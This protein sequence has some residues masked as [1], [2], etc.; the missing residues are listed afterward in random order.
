MDRIQ[1][2]SSYLLVIFNILLV[3][4]PLSLLILWFFIDVD[5]IKEAIKHGLLFGPVDTPEGIVNLGTIKWYPLTK[6]TGFMGSLLGILPILLGLMILKTI[7]RNYRKGEIFN[8]TNARQYKYLGYLFF[9][10]ALLTKPLSDM[11][12]VLSVTFTYPPGLRYISIGF[13]TPNMEALFCG[14][15]VIVISWV[16]VEGYKLQE[17]QKLI[18]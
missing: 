1:K 18:I 9:L 5:P 11:L 13:G 16:M 4:L 15:L 8:I 17:E 12:Q 7:F 6:F 2:I 3:V 14:I 10:D